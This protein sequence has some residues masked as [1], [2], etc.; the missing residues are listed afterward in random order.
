MT[1]EHIVLKHLF[2]PH[3]NLGVELAIILVLQL[4]FLFL[5]IKIENMQENLA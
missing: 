1:K 4:S 3:F 5:L 2:L